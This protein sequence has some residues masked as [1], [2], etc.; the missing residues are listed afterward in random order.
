LDSHYF[1]FLQA[2]NSAIPITLQT[3]YSYG[4]LPSGL[5]SEFVASSAPQKDGLVTKVTNVVGDPSD[6]ASFSF[7]P[8]ILCSDW[9]S[10][11]LF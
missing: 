8:V 4:Y 2:N 1:E 11:V 7:P 5:D 3:N 9:S 10:E 6:P